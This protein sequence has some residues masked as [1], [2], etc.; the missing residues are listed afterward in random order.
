MVQYLRG[1]MPHLLAGSGIADPF[2][3]HLVCGL[4]P[5][6][7][8][9]ATTARLVLGAPGCSHPSRQQL[10]RICDT[11]FGWISR[12]CEIQHDTTAVT[13]RRHVQPE[14]R[15]D[16]PEHDAEPNRRIVAVKGRPVDQARVNVGQA[17]FPGVFLREMLKRKRLHKGGV[18]PDAVY[19]IGS[20][21]GAPNGR[22]AWLCAVFKG[23]RVD[24][25]DVAGAGRCGKE[26]KESGD[27]SDARVVDGR[28]EGV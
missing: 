8:G 4:G 19:A 1:M 23:S 17:E 14:Q 6:P 25:D 3:T 5:L 20:G 27:E 26:R 24:G 21:R 15:L 2:V 28:E 9:V 7:D 10:F 12:R 11:P 22:F 18:L 13:G 16:A